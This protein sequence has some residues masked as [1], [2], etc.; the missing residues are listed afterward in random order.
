MMKIFDFPL[1]FYPPRATLMAF[2][3]RFPFERIT[4]NLFTA[5]N[6]KPEFLKISPSGT[7]PV[8]VDGDTTLTSSRQIVEYLDQKDGKPL[9]GDAVDRTAVK[10]WMDK[11]D[12]WDGNLF[13]FANS[14]ANVKS[15]LDQASWYK[16]R[17]IECNSKKHPDLKS[18]Y[19]ERLAAMTKAAN[20]AADTTVVEKNKE[21]LTSLLEQAD[22][23]LSKHEYLAGSE[24]TTADVLFTPVLYRVHNLNKQAEFLANRAQVQAYWKRIKARPS[25]KEA[26]GPAGDGLTALKLVGGGLL[27]IFLNKFTG[28]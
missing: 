3:K 9:G 20:D 23:Q 14:D 1:A 7:L 2:E 10:A 15:I 17:V 12:E 4:L 26:Y 16:K 27:R 25:F 24:Y 5:D 18:V 21:L 8:L 28:L 6:M 22:E 11:I 13:A 19:D